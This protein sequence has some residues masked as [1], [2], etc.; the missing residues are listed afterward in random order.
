MDKWEATED[1]AYDGSYIKN[2]SNKRIG[3]T[4]EVSIAKQI[5]HEHN[6]F[7]ELVEALQLSFDLLEI[8]MPIWYRKKHADEI[9]T[10][11][12]LARGK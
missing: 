2:E 10:A 7:Q 6:L 11:L 5:V 12:K 4:W 1:E 3:I 9:K 8:N